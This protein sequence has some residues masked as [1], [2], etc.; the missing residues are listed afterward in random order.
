MSQPRVIVAWILAVLY[1]GM[2]V[3]QLYWFKK[4]LALLVR[5]FSRK[6]GKTAT[7]SKKTAEYKPI[8]KSDTMKVD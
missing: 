6:D 7:G 3:L 4:I 1:V 8:S 2:F 5:S